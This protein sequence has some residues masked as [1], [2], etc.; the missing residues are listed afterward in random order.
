MYTNKI[1][2]HISG[3]IVFLLL[4]CSLII[5]GV[6]DSSL[7]FGIVE[8]WLCIAICGLLVVCGLIESVRYVFRLKR[9]SN[10]F[11]RDLE[12]NL[13]N[14]KNIFSNQHYFLNDSIF[15]FEIP[16]RIFYEDIENISEKQ[17]DSRY[18]GNL[19]FLEIKLKNKR[20]IKLK[21]NGS[22]SF[23]AVEILKKKSKKSFYNG[24][25]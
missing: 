23:N 14:C 18:A 9:I 16:D 13:R 10:S 21:M 6:S 11:D 22:D 2:K 24:E 3:L 7:R 4:F 5:W 8:K 15:T 25:I 17:R 1:I 19:Y 12:K 20:Q